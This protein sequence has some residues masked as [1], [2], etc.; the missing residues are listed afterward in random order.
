[1]FQGEIKAWLK[2]GAISSIGF[3]RTLKGTPQ[4]G[5]ISPLLA[6]IA[7]DGLE[8][9]FGIYSRYGRYL[10]PAKRTGSNKDVAVFRYA[11]DFIVLAPSKD[12]LV[13]YVIP[14]VTSFLG[15]VG[16]NLNDAKTR[17]VNIS[18]GFEFL[19][20]CFRRYYRRNGEIKEF[21][22]FPSRTR[23]DRFM[24]K[25]TNYVK[26]NQS[27]DVHEIIIAMNR[28]INGFCNYFK[29]SNAH[30]AFSYMGNRIYILML[31]W[32]KA[33]H[34]GRGVKWLVARYWTQVG[35]Y[36]WVFSFQGV[37]LLLPVQLTIKNWWKWPKV[38]LDTSPFDPDEADYWRQRTWKT[39]A[40]LEGFTNED[41]FHL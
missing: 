33:R 2:S 38:R 17:I 23:L 12:V 3:E 32:A 11:D 26:L 4:G 15:T 24:E 34:N 39:R 7:L 1:V 40:D 41:F 25:L 16:L 29:W 9:Q 20:F 36:N 6:N 10:V 5:V 30:R 18:E 27:K 21:T 14:K 37:H 35:N 19:G 31:R 13:N 22:Y 28:R 8:R